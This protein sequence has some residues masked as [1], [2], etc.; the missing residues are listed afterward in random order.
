[1]S[2]LLG[3]DEVDGAEYD[4]NTEND[5]K[6]LGVDEVDIVDMVKQFLVKYRSTAQFKGLEKE[7]DG[8]TAKF[9]Q[10]LGN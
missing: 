1:M 6:W 4:E 3:F 9:L 8:D 7:I 2:G 10:G 5:L